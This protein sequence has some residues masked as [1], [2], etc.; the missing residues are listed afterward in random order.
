MAFN[1]PSEQNWTPLTASQISNDLLNRIN[2]ILSSNSITNLL[3]PVISN[4]IWIYC[5]AVG[6]IRAIYDQ[7][8]YQA[9]QSLN[10]ATCSDNQIINLL[11]VIGTQKITATYTTIWIKFIANPSTVCTVTPT[12]T[13]TDGAGNTFVPLQTVATTSGGTA[14]V[15]CK[16]QTSGAIYVYDGQITSFVVNPSN[17]LSVVNGT[18]TIGGLVYGTITGRPDETATQIRQ[19]IING[20]V[21]DNSLNGFIRALTTIQGLGSINVVYNSSNAVGLSIYTST[22][23]ITLPP[24]EMWIFTQGSDLS[25]VDSVANIW[26]YYSLITTYNSGRANTKTQTVTTLSGQVLSVY[27]DVSVPQNVYVRVKIPASV[28]ANISSS[29]T[30]AIQ[31]QVLLLNNTYKTGSVV[32]SNV[33][34][35]VY[36]NFSGCT[37]YDCD[38]SLDGVNWSSYVNIYSDGVP[39]FVNNATYVVIVGV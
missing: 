14:Y 7:L 17:L 6:Q 33:V 28:Y 3:R 10:I 18:F 30:S 20:S 26:Y 39:V 24:R 36:D 34:S 38:V 32:T 1:Y 27:Y 19:R 35:D 15:Q 11:P 12:N 29:L 8:L 37:V 23:Y 9:T 25:G 22:G 5:L 13:L 4:V 31:N 16:C 2:T 21:I